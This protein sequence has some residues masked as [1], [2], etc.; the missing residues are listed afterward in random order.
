MFLYNIGIVNSQEF[1]K[2]R[3]DHGLIL[4]EDGRKMSKRWGNVINPS[5]IINSHGADAL[6]TYC[7]FIGPINGIYP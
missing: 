3:I 6:R 1:F 2:T 7:A 5:D 4:A